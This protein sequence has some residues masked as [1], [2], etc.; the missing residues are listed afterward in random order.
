MVGTGNTEGT[1]SGVDGVYRGRQL[2]L[3]TVNRPVQC[4][5]WFISSV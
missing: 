2:M 1:V 5:Y 3:E 4:N